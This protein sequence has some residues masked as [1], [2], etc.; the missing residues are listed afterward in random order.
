MPPQL[1][2]RGEGKARVSNGVVVRYQER[3]YM[4]SDLTKRWLQSVY[5]TLKR[6]DSD[7][8][9][10]DSFSGHISRHV[11]QHCRDNS[12]R[13]AIIPGGC[14]P[15]LQPLDIAV[16][17]SFKARFRSKWKAWLASNSAAAPLYAERLRAMSLDELTRIINSAWREI[18][19][20]VI[21]N[22]FRKAQIPL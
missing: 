5:Q 21:I 15:H 19:P 17:R 4:T 14:T 3:A 18:D 13:L 11:K 10:M 12:V 6:S 22:G 9:I 7:I 20:Q 2:V 16:N 1:V 8:L